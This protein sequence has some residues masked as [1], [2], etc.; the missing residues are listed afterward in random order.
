MKS[1]LKKIIIIFGLLLGLIF[2]FFTFWPAAGFFLF[3]KALIGVD[4]NHFLYYVTEFSKHLIFPATGW[5]MTWYQGVSQILDNPWFN[6][7]L[8]QPLVKIWGPLMATKIYLIFFLF[9]FLFFSFLVFWELSRDIFLSTV[10]A[11]AIS[12]SWALYILLYSAGTGL[13]SCAQVAFPAGLFGLLRYLKTNQK[14][15]LGL[16]I[17]AASFGFYTH[18]LVAILIIFPTILLFFLLHS[19]EPK[20][21]LD[22]QKI[23]ELLVFVAAVFLLSLPSLLPGI[24]DFIRGGSYRGAAFV[25]FGR[26]VSISSLFQS[27]N[28]AFYLFL[29]IAFLASLW[30]GIKRK[31]GI[32]IPLAAVGFYFLAW[33]IS[34]VLG[35][36]PLV[37]VLFPHR[38]YWMAPF[39]LGA[40]IAVFLSHREKGDWS[41]K[42]VVSFLALAFLIVAFWFDLD[43]L[44]LKEVKNHVPGLQRILRGYRPKEYQIGNLNTRLEEVIDKEKLL[45]FSVESIDTEDIN[46][47]LWVFDGRIRILW[48]MFYPLPQ[49]HGYFHYRT[50][51]AADWF[52][53]LL[54]TVAREGYEEDSGIPAHIAKPQSLFLTDWYAIRFLATDNFSDRDVGPHFY[55]EE[56]PYVLKKTSSRPPAGIE[57]SQE[58]ISEIA[59]LT[60]EPVLG[61]VGREKA[62]DHFLRNLGMLNL[63][64][65][66]LVPIRAGHFIEDLSADEL[67]RF[68]GLV[69]YDYHKKASS[70]AYQEAWGRLDQFIQEGGFVWV[71]TGAECPEKWGEEIPNP[72]PVYQLEKGSLGRSWQVETNFFTDFDFKSLAPLTY[73]E[74]TWN[75]SFVPSES[76]I[77]PEAKVLLRQ[78]GKPVIV[79]S[80]KGEGKIIWSGLNLFYRA[81]YHHDE[82]LAEVELQKRIYQELMTL[83]GKRID[84]E[85]SRPQSEKVILSSSGARG[86]LLKEN[87]YGGWTAWA[88]VNNQKIQLPVLAAGPDFMYAPLPDGLGNKPVKVEFIYRGI[89][90]DWLFFIIAIITLFFVLDLI[91]FNQRIFNLAYLP[92][93][94]RIKDKIKRMRNKVKKSW[95]EEEG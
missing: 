45:G 14:R 82:A 74:G 41:R 54:A 68:D 7:I 37:G 60:D 5:K 29:P 61:F 64:S 87:N 21:L 11:A 40:L 24:L 93:K 62:Y 43:G 28:V 15:W 77:K 71:E 75:V 57:L 3:E 18:V 23:K 35:I 42:I 36:N 31:F 16:A 65:N 19:T 50:A 92:I 59:R 34:F 51:R 72:F 94:N 88:T 52:A 8:I 80:K 1:L 90:Y 12:R 83:D 30:L 4:S 58:Y 56:N 67:A 81:L 20:P 73:E 55:Q 27:I 13:S 48:N 66:Y 69:I 84:F 49:V 91:I 2:V 70:R 26:S 95:E 17:I 85:F 46:H 38:I 25:P 79:E 47:R 9:L 22:R 76:G 89:W 6:F 10:L 53:W 32:L 78:A 39:L 44:G 33:Q 63:N 86:A